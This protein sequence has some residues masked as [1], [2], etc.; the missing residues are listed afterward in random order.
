MVSLLRNTQSGSCLHCHKYWLLMLSVKEFGFY[1]L[2]A[3]EIFYHT[4]N[5]TVMGDS[6]PV[7][8][9]G[10]ITWLLLLPNFLIYFSPLWS[11]TLMLPC[12][13]QK[14]IFSLQIH[15]LSRA[16]YY[17]LSQLCSVARSLTPTVT[18][19]LSFDTSSA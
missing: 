9:K 14:L 10:G 5:C 11:V 12:M 16:C 8:S 1:V 4:L 17:Q 7:G 6:R 13:D 18:L 19:V 3:C 2:K 15:S